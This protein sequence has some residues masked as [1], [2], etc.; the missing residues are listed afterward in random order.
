VAGHTG[1]RKRRGISVLASVSSFQLFGS[2]P[3]RRGL[4][5]QQGA[6]C[7]GNGRRGRW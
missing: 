4:R 7:R 6:C 3:R 5:L 1:M 2:L